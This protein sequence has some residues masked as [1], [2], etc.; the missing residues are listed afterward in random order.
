MSMPLVNCRR[1]GLMTSLAVFVTLGVV[2]STAHAGSRDEFSASGASA[3]RLG[4]L[5][6]GAGQGAL[7]L[8]L[9]QPAQFQKAVSA[10]LGSRATDSG[11]GLYVSLH[12]PW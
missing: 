2:L 9:N 1:P 8:S 5:P 4:H 7:Q 11:R 12:M 3:S 6:M 10:P